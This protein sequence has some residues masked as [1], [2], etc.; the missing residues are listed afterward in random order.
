MTQLRISD[1][2][3][4]RFVERTGL[5]DLEPLRLLLAASLARAMAAAEALDEREV[6]IVADGLIYVVRDRVLVTVMPD[7]RGG[8]HAR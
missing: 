2:A 5:V 8:T 3:L 1:H 6:R 4:L 7:N